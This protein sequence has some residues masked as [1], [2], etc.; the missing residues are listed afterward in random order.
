MY[1]DVTVGLINVQSTFKVDV[2]LS[3]LPL[4]C[5][6]YLQYKYN[7]IQKIKNTNTIF[8]LPTYLIEGPV[9][10]KSGEV[11][12]SIFKLK[13]LFVILWFSRNLRALH[14]LNKILPIPVFLQF[15][16]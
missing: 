7:L 1:I 11:H 2:D 14:I 6:W 16:R 8:H 15:Q 9:K 12:Q 3:F 13:Y 4:W 10:L 5:K